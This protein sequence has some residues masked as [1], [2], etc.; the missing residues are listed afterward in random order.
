MDRVFFRDSRSV[1]ADSK[2]YKAHIDEILQ[3][4]EVLDAIHSSAQCKEGDAAGVYD[5]VQTIVDELSELM[6]Q[7]D[8]KC[9]LGP[10]PAQLSA[11]KLPNMPV[12][13]KCEHEPPHYVDVKGVP[14]VPLVH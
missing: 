13:F 11:V 14:I 4:I 3:H 8:A 7:I 12:C 5:Y 9:P 6:Q 10:V 2:A 1:T